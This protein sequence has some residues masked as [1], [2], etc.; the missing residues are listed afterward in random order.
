MER[1]ELLTTQ[2][3]SAI[4]H[5]KPETLARKLSQGKIRGVKV[6]RQWLIRRAVVEAMLEPATAKEGL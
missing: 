1:E 6:G 2:Q 3:A 5:L 4:L